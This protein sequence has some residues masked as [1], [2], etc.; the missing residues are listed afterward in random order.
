M[1]PLPFKIIFLILFFTFSLAAQESNVIIL[2]NADVFSGKRYANGEDV[3][4]LEGNVKFRQGAVRVWCDKAIQFLNRNEIELNGNVKLVRDTVTLTARKGRYFGNTKT[5]ICEGNVK[6]RSK[7]ITIFSDLGTYYTEEKRAYFQKNVRVVDSSSTIFSDQLT[8]YEKE[9]KSIAT[10]NVRIFNPSDNVTMYG[11]YLE[12]FDSTHYSKMTKNPRLMQIDTS[13]KGEIDTLAVKSIV[14]ESFDDSSKRLIATDSVVIVRGQLAARSGLVRYFRR[15]DKIE[16]FTKPIVWYEE[17]QVTGDSV[18]LLLEKNRL[19]EAT[20]RNRAFVLSQ[21]DSNFPNRFNQL[22]G[23]LV[24]MK[25]KENKLQETVVERN[26][27]SLYFLYDDKTP[28]GVNKTSG[29]YIRMTFENGKPHTIRVVKGIEGNYFPE[30]IVKKDESQY[31]L[32]GFTLHKNRPN[33]HSV[34]QHKKK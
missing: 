21:S 9:R 29:D 26:A 14:M 30:N 3:R 19:R 33:F 18:T 12:H 34:F 13:A 27:T 8:Y 4:E 25:F 11:D 2:E 15:V 31:N 17:N 7:S 23:R 32:D 22:N 28:N 20:I 24:V 6:L 10:S 1:I 16:L 5:A